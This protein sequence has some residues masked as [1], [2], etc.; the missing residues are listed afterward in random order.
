MNR[1]IVDIKENDNLLDS[2]DVRA[3]FPIF[4]QE[5]NG[6]P[7]VYLDSASSAQKPQIVLDTLNQVLS[8]HYANIHRGVYD[9]SQKTTREYEAARQTISDFIGAGDTGE[10]IFTRNA[11][12]AMNLVAYSWAEA[13]MKAG[14]SVLITEMEHHANIVPW[15]LLRK[16]QGI[17]IKVIPIDRD[18]DLDLS[19]ISEL[20]DKK[21]KLLSFVHISNAIGTYNPVEAII[22][23][24]KKGNSDIKIMVDG[25]QAV[26][27]KPV[28]ISGYKACIRPDF[29]AFTGHKLYGP[30]GIGI[31]YAGHNV[32]ESMQPFLGGGDMIESVSFEQTTF[33]SAPGKFEAGT[34]PIA[35]VIALASAIDFLHKVSL[36]AISLH[37]DA[38]LHHSQEELMSIDGVHVVGK[39][40]KK[41]PVISFNIDGVHPGDV[42]MVLDQMGVAIRSGHHCCMPLMQKLGFEGTAR[43]SFGLYNTHDDVESFLRAVHKS[44]QI[45]R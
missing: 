6:K 11:T 17:E 33:K 25:T 10:I 19:K 22:S 9:F 23:E 3:Q 7:F 40:R 28:D 35:E 32:L 5:M 15:Q 21:T 44:V 26:V 29:Y 45:L 36:E 41:G 39:Q 18:G 30:N 4:Q 8:T 37:E 38:L 34:P 24:A 20:C 42:G 16:R 13:N 1:D 14:E 43:A 2:Q 27:H 12:E 31:L